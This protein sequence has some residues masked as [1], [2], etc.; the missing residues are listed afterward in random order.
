M[1]TR[2]L[3]DTNHL[4][5]ALAPVSRVRE[6]IQQT[7]RAGM[8]LGTCVPVLCELEVGIQQT[9]KP[10]ANRRALMTLLKQVRLWPI[11]REMARTYGEIYLDLRG[12]G[13][14]LSQVDMMLAA[15]A[16]RMNLTLLT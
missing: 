1:I 10:E 16:E 15:L 13:R 7:R 12:R 3:L 11:E 6:R 2:Y 4:A 8:I 14:V 5:A 9:G